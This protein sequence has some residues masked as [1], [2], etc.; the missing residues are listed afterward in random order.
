MLLTIRFCKPVTI[1]KYQ[2]KKS[3]SFNKVCSEWINWLRYIFARVEITVGS[4]I[5]RVKMYILNNQ[6]KNQF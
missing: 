2:L 6:F 3:R 1:K 5:V 4:L